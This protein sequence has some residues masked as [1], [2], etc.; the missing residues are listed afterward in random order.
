LAAGS[1]DETALPGIER[2]TALESLHLLGCRLEPSWL[3]SVAAGVTELT[4]MN[5]TLHS[6]Q[7]Q[8][9]GVSQLLQLLARFST[10]R[11][12]ILGNIAGGWPQQLSLLSALTAGSSLQEM[13]VYSTPGVSWAHVFPAGRTLPNLRSFSAHGEHGVLTPLGS[14]DITR[15]VACCPGL[16]EVDFAPAAAASLDPLQSLTALES[17]LLGPVSP[18][19][20]DFVTT[21]TQLKDLELFL[22]AGDDAAEAGL[23]DLVPLTA[24]TG[25]T[26]LYVAVIDEQQQG[27][28]EGNDGR[29]PAEDLVCLRNKVSR[30]RCCRLIRKPRTASDVCH[31][32]ARS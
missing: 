22:S 4:L 14:A 27:D 18:T 3:L 32:P 11:R 19:A 28:G 5:D 2:L 15:L 23:C 20:V 1:I 29:E 17:L 26:G 7:A 24:L 10:L 6:Q 25:L 21:L 13:V 16:T 30:Q 9:D 8:Q 31:T 12:L